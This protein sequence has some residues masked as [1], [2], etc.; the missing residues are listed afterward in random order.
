MYI[1]RTLR[2]THHFRQVKR[3]LSISLFGDRLRCNVMEV[4]SEKLRAL[5]VVSLIE[6]LVDGMRSIRRAAHWQEENFFAGRLFEGQGDGDTR[7]L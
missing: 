1:M 7:F 6:F 2:Q 5:N 4:R 3:I